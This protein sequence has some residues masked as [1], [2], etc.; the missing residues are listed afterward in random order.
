MCP[1][2]YARSPASNRFGGF[3]E[4]EAGKA[5][6]FVASHLAPIVLWP[7]TSSSC[8]DGDDNA[9]DDD[10]DD[11]TIA[12]TNNY[13]NNTEPDASRSRIGIL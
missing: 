13:S 1:G 10:N 11:H 7:P 8:G 4:A 12:S 3:Q 9:N 6:R 2:F 5:H